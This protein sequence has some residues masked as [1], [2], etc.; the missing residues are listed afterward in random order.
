MNRRI[1]T[2][3]VLLVCSS[4][5]LADATVTLQRAALQRTATQ[6][7]E[8]ILTLEAAE[9]VL[10]V[11]FDLRY[12]PQELTFNGARTLLPEFSFDYRE[13]GNGVIRGLLYNLT[14]AAVDANA[15]TDIIGFDFTPVTGFTGT[16]TVTFDEVILAGARGVKI[17]VSA[18]P[19]EVNTAAVPTLTRLSDCWP[20]PFNPVTTIQYDLAHEGSVNIAVYDLR[21]RMVTELVNTV[22]P[23]GSYRLQWNARNH[24]SGL[25]WLRF[26]SQDYSQSQ[27][28]LLLK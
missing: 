10:G 7:R 8:V 3:S 6:S 26:I 9:P 1:I 20:N 16:S 19:G 22:Q 4:L 28:L 15:L 25:Y 23:A 17:P 2:I 5:L 11:Q 18:T 27:K 21:G 14:G 24:A 12:D 13:K